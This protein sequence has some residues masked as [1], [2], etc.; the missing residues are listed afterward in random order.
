MCIIWDRITLSLLL[1]AILLFSKIIVALYK[2]VEDT[3]VEIYNHD[4]FVLLFAIFTRFPAF[5]DVDGLAG[6]TG[7]YALPVLPSLPF[8]LA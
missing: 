4:L 6:E 7:L 8:T 2:W 1:D 3:T 5:A